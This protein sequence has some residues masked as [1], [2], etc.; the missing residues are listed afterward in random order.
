MFWILAIVIFLG[1]DVAYKRH[2]DRVETAQEQH[3]AEATK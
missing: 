2:A 3:D 1:G